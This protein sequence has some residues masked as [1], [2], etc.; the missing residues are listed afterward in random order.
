MDFYLNEVRVLNMLFATLSM[1]LSVSYRMFCIIQSNQY[2][3][4]Q[5]IENKLFVKFCVCVDYIKFIFQPY[6]LLFL[7]RYHM[8][9]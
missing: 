3:K 6:F 2:L 5:R 8:S 9:R 1:L 4:E 7:E